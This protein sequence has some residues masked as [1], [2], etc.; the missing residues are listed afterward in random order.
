M[1]AKNS[2]SVN[3]KLYTSM[4]AYT[5]KLLGRVVGSERK[6]STCCFNSHC[7]NLKL[8]KYIRVNK[9]RTTIFTLG[10]CKPNSYATD[11]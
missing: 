9:T 3:T 10:S 8:S 5:T 6:Y 11:M 1:Y 2:A 7:G 4:M